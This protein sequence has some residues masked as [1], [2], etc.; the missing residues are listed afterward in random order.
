[1]REREREGRNQDPYQEARLAKE[2]PT[3][4]L[5]YYAWTEKGGIKEGEVTKEGE[6]IKEV[7]L[8]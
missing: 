7:R 5:L 6:M 8:D 3:D 4:V 1:V 2:L